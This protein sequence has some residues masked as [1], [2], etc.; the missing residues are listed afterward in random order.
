MA[1][2]SRPPQAKTTNDTN[3]TNKD[4]IGN[5]PCLHRRNPIGN[6][7][8]EEDFAVPL[9]DHFRSPLDDLRHWEGF[10]GQW[11]AMIVLA[12][13]RQLPQRYFAEPRVH[14]GGSAEIDVAT[15]HE[16]E[17]RIFDR[18]RN[19]RLVAAVEIVSPANKERPE[20]LR[21]FVANC[22]CPAPK[23]RL[24]HHP[25]CGHHSQFQS[26]RRATGSFG[27]ERSVAGPRTTDTVRRDL[28]VDEAGRRL[29]AGNLGARTGTGSAAADAATVAR[30]QL[31]GAPR[32]GRDLREDVS[33]TPHRLNAVNLARHETEKTNAAEPSTIPPRRCP[34]RR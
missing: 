16:Y 12:L 19:C 22:G 3:S 21:A 20:H 7:G 9:R 25:R 24:R 13:L 30:R 34:C 18:K 1:N 28:P 17:V 6:N 10:H 5:W 2:K 32:V 23:P 31:R 27:P 11:P 14:P 33:G 26:L 15:F 29:A 4:R 8:S